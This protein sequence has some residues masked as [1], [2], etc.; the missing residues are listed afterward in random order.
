MQHSATTS[1]HGYYHRQIDDIIQSQCN[2]KSI[3]RLRMTF[4]YKYLIS[5]LSKKVLLIPRDFY[6]RDQS[7]ETNLFH[8]VLMPL[9]QFK[10]CYSFHSF[11]RHVHFVSIKYSFTFVHYVSVLYSF[12][13]VFF[14]YQISSRSFFCDITTLCTICTIKY[15]LLTLQHIH[16]TKKHILCTVKHIRTK[17]YILCTVDHVLR[18]TFFAP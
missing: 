12:T 2:F 11:L 9:T 5:K 16:E 8:V 14:A 10:H 18:S 4:K 1:S 6:C 17:K 7:L 15:Y 13:F 3:L